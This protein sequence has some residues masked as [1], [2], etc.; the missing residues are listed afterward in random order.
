MLANGR[1]FAGRNNSARYQ[2]F[3]RLTPYALRPLAVGQH[4]IGRQRKHERQFGTVL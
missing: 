2:F 1:P 4:R 3:G